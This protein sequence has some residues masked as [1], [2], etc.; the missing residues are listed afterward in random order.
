MH[1]LFRR[2]VRGTR[3]LITGLLVSFVGTFA[4]QLAALAECAQATTCSRPDA[5]YINE[6]SNPYCYEDGPDCCS[7]TKTA[8]SYI[9][10]KPGQTCL[11]VGT[12]CTE[13]TNRQVFF[14]S[15]CS[16]GE[17]CV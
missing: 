16:N 14:Y 10:S 9:G 4:Y 12:T 13:Y 6:S 2:S 11:L 3:H 17:T 8:V 15:A 1:R 5:C 7:Y